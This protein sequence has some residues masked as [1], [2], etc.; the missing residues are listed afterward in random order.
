MLALDDYFG[1]SFRD[2]I[3]EYGIFMPP[4]EGGGHIMLPLSVCSCVCVCVCGCVFPKS[5][6]GHNFVIPG[7]ILK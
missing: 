5:C 7:W 1:K 4:A 6:P 2:L 3:S